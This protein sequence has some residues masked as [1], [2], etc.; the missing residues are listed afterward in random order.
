MRIFLAVLMG[1]F[2]FQIAYSQEPEV[3][4][5]FKKKYPDRQ[6]VFLNRSRSLSFFF[7]GDSLQA[8]E[9]FEEELL[10]LKSLT[11]VFVRDKVHGS[12]LVPVS[13][14]VAK[15]MVWD[16]TRYKDQIVK[17]FVKS[18][19]A[20]EGIFFDDSYQYAFSFPSISPMNKTYLKYTNTYRDVRFLPSF[21]IA[22]YYPQEN[23]KY[24]IKCP[25]E[26]KIHF[27]IINDKD[28]KI[29]FKTYEKSGNT[30]YEWSA[31]DIKPEKPEEGAPTITYYAP[32][33]VAYVESYQSKEITHP[34]LSD[35]NSLYK[36]YSTFTSGLNG[37]LSE[38]L[39]SI[40][41]GLVKE[42]EDEL[43]KV[44]KI[45]YWVQEN[46]K[47]IAFEQGMRGLIPHS[48]SYVCD[49]RFGDC[50]D[51][52]S[53][54]VD[55]MRAANIKAYYTW[56]GTRDIPYL[57]S[58]MPTPI[59]D[60]HMI[61]TYIGANNRYY[62]L[63]ATSKHT[64]FGLPSSM[65]QGKEALI[66]LGADK[67][68]VKQVPEI[69]KEVN[70]MVDSM[71]IEIAN[72]G[73]IGK[74]TTHLQGYPKVFSG[75]QLNRSVNDAQ[76]NYVT[77]LVSKGSNK[78]VLKDYKLSNLAAYDVPTSVDY[79]FQIGDYVKK[80]GDELY[81]NLCLNRNYYNQ[82]L[83]ADR[84]VPKENEY[85]YVLDEYY[86]LTL[87]SGYT[88]EYLPKNA[89]HNGQLLG[90]DMKYE[91]K[92][93][94]I[95]LSK[96]LHIDYLMMQPESIKDWNASVRKISEAYQESIILKSKK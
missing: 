64:A 84:S 86:E 65:I 35:L 38:Q 69:D 41:K 19:E 91:L 26:V 70:L 12:D 45:F 27:E 48:G 62:F 22:H 51:M 46:I 90:F 37:E 96:K 3:Y 60:N 59:V 80:V 1:S 76:L 25:K 8:Q 88:V 20:D 42:E 61:A 24:T 29:Q 75:Y 49:K 18:S 17:E 16:G 9:T 6:A 94:K 78:F 33:V 56:I 85:K 79:K 95:L 43:V 32:H 87:P 89:N 50:K 10:L 57:Y 30:F 66:G 28:K 93:N 44:K 4:T 40:V 54:L 81:I 15:T 74:G 82:Y 77:K 55:M 11:D 39:K 23:S 52:S 83:E 7:K 31:T 2:V 67:F 34:V 5:Q 63:D 21:I 73:I 71:K 68:E 14:I 53:L 92:G 72:T 36:W 47:Y 58:K 13:N